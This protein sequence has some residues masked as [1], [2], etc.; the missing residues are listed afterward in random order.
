MN[1]SNK[2]DKV[3][4]DLGTVYELVNVAGIHRLSWH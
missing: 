3:A 2:E 4:I 1:P